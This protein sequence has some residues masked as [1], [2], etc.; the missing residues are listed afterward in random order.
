MENQPITNSSETTPINSAPIVQSPTPI[1]TKTNL[2]VP[3]LLTVLV[4]AI[5]FGVGGYFLGKSISGNTQEP[6]AVSNP[7]NLP[8]PTITTVPNSPTLMATI[9]PTA[10]WKVF[11]DSK[12]GFLFKHPSRYNLSKPAPGGDAPNEGS[13]T[14]YAGSKVDMFFFDTISFTGSVDQFVKK[15]TVLEPAN[16]LMYTNLNVSTVLGDLVKQDNPSI[17]VYKYVNHYD[18]KVN[19][20]AQDISTYTIFFVQNNKGFIVRANNTFD[21]LPEITQMVTSIKN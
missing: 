20:G 8:T 11:T 18:Q 21:N 2:V 19:P 17:T 12:L 7:Q 5:V 10:N 15:Y 4:S 9:D 16:G 13:Y 1:Q 6:V 3:I 14:F